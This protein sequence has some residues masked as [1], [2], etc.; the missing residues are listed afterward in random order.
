MTGV[1]IQT[2]MD[3]DAAGKKGSLDGK[4]NHTRKL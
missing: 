3:Y 1:Y 4:L 2:A